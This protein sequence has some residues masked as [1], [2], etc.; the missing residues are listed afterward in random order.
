VG[1]VNQQ[2]SSEEPGISICVPTFKRR[3]MLSRCLDAIVGQVDVSVPFVVIVVDNDPLGTAR[4]VVEELRNRSSLHVRYIHEPRQSISIA[5]NTAVANAE[6]KYIAFIDDDECPE[7]TWLESLYQALTQ[8][9]ADGVLGPVLP[10][11]VEP[12][13]DW[14]VKSRLCDRESFRTGTLMESAKHL[15]AGN[16]F[17]KREVFTGISAPFDPALGRTGGEDADFLARMVAKG[18]RFVW[19]DEARVFEE[20]PIER[21]TLHYHL[22]RALVRGVTEADRERLISYGTLKSLA[23]VVVYSLILPV[24]FFTSRALF[25]R[26]AVK[27]CDHAAK[28]LAKLGIKLVRE[29][30]F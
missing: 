27:W 10:N 28:L 30:N 25:A 13:P 2:T 26:Y 4:I 1:L 16:L 3:E 14:L 15:R 24:L 19:C 17:L 29:R 20:V 23:A 5:R 21:Q 6:G 9:D 7:S 18:F 22:Q 12:P 8:F 11:F